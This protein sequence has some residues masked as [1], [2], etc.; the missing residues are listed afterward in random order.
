MNEHYNKQVN[1]FI[2]TFGKEPEDAPE[3]W[4]A[5]T[6]GIKFQQEFA[7]KDWPM[8]RPFHLES[9]LFAYDKGWQNGYDGRDLPNPFTEAGSQAAAYAE[10]VKE[11]TERRAIHL[12]AGTH[13]ESTDDR[14][15]RERHEAYAEGYDDGK[16][17]M[18][19]QAQELNRGR[20]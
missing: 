4:V 14:I 9:I 5:F 11:G 1:F 3:Q 16:E 10:G 7:A 12:N 8:L 18:C 13:P 20:E 19:N 6:R 17:F 2:N 15:R